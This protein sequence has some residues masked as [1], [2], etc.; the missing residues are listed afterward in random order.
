[1]CRTPCPKSRLTALHIAPTLSSTTV[2]AS[3]AKSRRSSTTTGIRARRIPA[4]LSSEPSHGTMMKPSTRL[5]M[6]VRTMRSS[7][8]GFSS[9]L[10]IS[11]V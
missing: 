4:M 3:T 1:M 7:F 2:G 6:K 8:E 9:V 5:S 11:T 10:P